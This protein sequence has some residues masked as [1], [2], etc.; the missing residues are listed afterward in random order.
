MSDKQI[1]ARAGSVGALILIAGLA[2]LLTLGGAPLAAHPVLLGTATWTPTPTPTST[3]TF[4]PTPTQT[5]TF[6]STPS[7]TPTPTSTPTPTLTPTVAT[8]TA[9]PAASHLWLTFP[10]GPDSGGDRYPGTYFPYGATGG[11]KYHLHH[12]VDYMNPNGTPVL[13]TGSGTVIVAGNDLKT[14][15]GLEPN[16]YGNLV[17]EQL[18]LDFQG[19]PVYVLYGHMSQLIAKVGQHVEAGD[20]VGLVGMTGAGAGCDRRTVGRCSGPADPRD[21]YYLFPCRRTKQ[22]VAAD[23]N[24]RSR[25]G[26]C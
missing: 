8:P 7:V 14:V 18:D 11:G 12:G 15:Y 13:A 22:V 5:P 16:F 24:L 10:V 25:R 4:T 1:V 21:T 23:P 9:A 26:E 3:P 17:I 2:V 6:T 19:Q 20:V